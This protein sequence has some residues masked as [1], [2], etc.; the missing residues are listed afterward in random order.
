MYKSGKPNP[1]KFQVISEVE[2]LC[3]EWHQGN[4]L[5]SLKELNDLV[6]LKDAIE[7]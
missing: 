7:N 3:D 6:A 1:K 5:T 2:V 4:Y